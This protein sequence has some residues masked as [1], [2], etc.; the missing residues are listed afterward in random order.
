MAATY[1]LWLTTGAGMRIVSLDDALW[2][3]ATRVVNDVGRFQVGLPGSFDTA[4]IKPDRM[5]QIWRAPEGGRLSLW[6]PFFIRKWRYEGSG[7]VVIGGPDVNDLLRRRIVAAYSGSSQASKVGYADDMMKGMVSEAVADGV[8]PTPD[9]GTRVWDNFSVQADLGLGPTLTM[10]FAWRRLDRRL[11]KIS[12]AARKAGT[13][14]FFDIVASDVSGGSISLEF[15]TYT[16]QPGRDRTGLGMVFDQERGNLEDP[17]LVYDYTEEIN[18][19]YAGGQGQQSER[20]VQ[21]VYDEARYNVSAWGRCEGF[22]EA[23]SQGAANGVREMGRAM[24]EGYRP[25]RRFGGWPV[26]T[27]GTRFG[28]DWD[29][30]DKIRARYRGE[31]FD[32]IVRVTSVGVDEGGKETTPARMEYEE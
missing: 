3:N 26:D 25:R 23:R 27:A 29:H 10:S 19:V 12:R 21:Q 16:G 24:L 8:A 20:E 32:A 1:E 22:A 14:V 15:R 5:V 17:F 7:G 28:K 18:Y 13:E 9:A 31:E 2:F 11:P 30:G 4:L 6:R